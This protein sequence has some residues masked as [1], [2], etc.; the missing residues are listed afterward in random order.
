MRKRNVAI[1]ALSALTAGMLVAVVLP[2]TGQVTGKT[3]TLCEKDSKDYEAEVDNGADGFSAGDVF[4][5]SEP[6]FDTNGDRV[7]KTFGQGTI[8]KDFE[9]DAIVQFNVSLHLR[10]GDIEVQSTG[11]FS[12][13]GGGQ[14]LA[15]VGGTGKYNNATGVVKIYGRG[16]NGVKDSKDRLKVVLN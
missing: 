7:G 15:I 16:C 14:P 2:A 6:E 13:L 3:F 12:Q 1:L 11:K 8:L 9:R 10:G 4:I 5:F